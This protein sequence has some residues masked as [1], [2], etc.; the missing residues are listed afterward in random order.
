MNKKKISPTVEV[1]TVGSQFKQ[2]NKLIK[3]FPK[4]FY[5]AVV[6]KQHQHQQQLV[7]Q[8]QQLV[9]FHVWMA[10]AHR[11]ISH[12]GRN[13]RMEMKWEKK[14]QETKRV[15]HNIYISHWIPNIE[16]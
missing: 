5:F 3:W 1:V 16:P 9:Y 8:Q 6:T 2:C 14:Q 4:A 13:K 11:L 7:S 12:C 15:S 10:Y